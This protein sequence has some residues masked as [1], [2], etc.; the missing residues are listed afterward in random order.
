MKSA[1]ID[2]GVVVNIIAGSVPGS[3]DITGLDP[4][5]QIGWAYADGEFS[6]PVEPD[7]EPVDYG[8]KI[9]VLSFLNRFT[10]AE[11]LALRTEAKTNVVVED[12]LG[13]VTAASFID[14]TDAQTIAGVGYLESEELI[15][16]GRADEI[17]TDPVTETE[18]YK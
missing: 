6:A 2:N 8:T 1:I 16:T 18:R 4:R 12:F 7:P 13:L 15:G 17:L 5:P 11:R 9:T 14:L 3:I 10:Q